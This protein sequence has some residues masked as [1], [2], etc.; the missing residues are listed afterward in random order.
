[1]SE[2]WISVRLRTLVAERAGRRCEYCGIRE[3]DTFLGCQVDHI[4]SEKHGGL[5]REDNLAFC[6]TPCNRAKGTDL[7]GIDQAGKIVPLFNPR[8]DRW[9]EHFRHQGRHIIGVTSKGQAT[10]RVLRFNAPERLDE[11]DLS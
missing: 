10:V 6:C 3:A 11:R 8:I 9:E 5:T 1:M 4:I 7:A 2:T